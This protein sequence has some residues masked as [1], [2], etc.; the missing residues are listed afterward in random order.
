MRCSRPPGFA[1]RTISAS[2]RRAS[3]T[4]CK[5]CLQTTRSNSAEPNG[6]ASAS[7]TSKSV[8]FPYPAQ[9]S[10]ARARCGSSRSIPTKD[11]PSKRPARRATISPVPH[12]TSS[13]RLPAGGGCPGE[14]R[15][16]LRPDRFRLR[17]EVPHHRLV[18]HLLR[19]RAARIH[20]GEPYRST[21]SS[22]RRKLLSRKQ[23]SEAEVRRQVD[24]RS[25]SQDR[26]GE[27]DRSRPERAVEDRVAESV[28]EVQRR[29]RP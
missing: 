20:G 2:A 12:P 15:F 17:G 9:R 19:L 13:Q 14:D 23:A 5:T 22:A 27:M 29:T 18:R 10:R 1:T 8:R 16:L 6:S 25:Q 24:Q 3:G 28:I 26:N 4:A 11:A 7:P 21:S